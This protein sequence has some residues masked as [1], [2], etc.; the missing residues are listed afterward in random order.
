MSDFE[1]CDYYYS[2]LSSKE[3]EAQGDLKHV[4][5]L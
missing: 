1:A 3:T 2:H 5:I 4:A